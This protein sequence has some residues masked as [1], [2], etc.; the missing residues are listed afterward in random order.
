MSKHSSIGASSAHRWFEC[1]GSVA[2]AKKAPPQP[3]SPAA[4]QGTAAHWVIEQVLKSETKLDPYD[5]VG[6]PAPNGYVLETE[7]IDAVDEFLDI[8]ERDINTGKFVL[9][10]EASVNLSVIHP[11]LYSTS[12]VILMESNLKRLK[13]YDYKHGSGVPVQV[14]GNKQLMYYAL[15]AIQYVCTKHKID[16]LSMMGWGEVFKEVEVVIVQPRCRHIDGPERRWVIPGKELDQ[17]AVDLKAAAKLT[18]KK[19]A[20]LKTGDHCKWCPGIAICPAFNSK[21]FELAR[22]D[23]QKVSDPVNLNLVEPESLSNHEIGKILNFADL[24]SDWLKAVEAYALSI[25]E[26]GGVVPGYKLV[27]KRT[28]REWTSEE[29][30]L[31]VLGTLL[32][33][34][35][36]WTKKFISP[37]AAEK[38]LKKNKKIIEGIVVKPLGGH[39]LAPEHDPRDPVKASAQSDFTQLT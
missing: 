16:Y 38:L 29:E 36:L 15:G 31:S 5:F 27:E 1:P 7:D 20:A 21:T 33:D 18:Q 35:E 10:S 30:A 39:T 6:K 3:D 13:V 22:A 9:E 28:N 34:E 11:D 19:D 25:V 23:F 26:R 4:K 14:E 24:I 32:S 17:F 37:A 12:D 8:V 2:L